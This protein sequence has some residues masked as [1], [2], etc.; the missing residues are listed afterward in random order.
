MS[1]IKSF[2]HSLVQ[3]LPVTVLHLAILAIF[4]TNFSFDRFFIGWDAI[5]P[6]LN[7]G[8]NFHRSFFA[9]WQENYGVGALT[10][11]GFAALLPHTLISFLISL[12]TPIWANRQIVTFLCLY[13]GALGMYVLMEKILKELVANKMDNQ[14]HLL[15]VLPWVSLAASFFY[16]F[17]LATIQIFFIQLEAFIFHYA[18]LPWMFLTLILFI[19]KPSKKNAFFLFLTNFIFS[20]QAFVPSLFVSYIGAVVL[21]MVVVLIS[22]RPFVKTF[23]NLLTTAFIIFC[24]NAYWFLVFA[25]YTLFKSSSFLTAYNNLIST[26]DFVDK[27]AKYG[28]FKSVALLKSF[29]LDGYQYKEYMFQPWLNHFQIPVVQGI[30]YAFFAVICLGVVLGILKSKAWKI[31]GMFLFSVFFFANIA[32]STFPFSLLIQSLQKISPTFAQAF[33]TSFSKFGLGLGFSYSVFFG[34][35]VFLVL[36]FLNRFIPRKLFLRALTVIVLIC[37]VYYGSPIFQGN[38]LYKNLKVKIPSSYQEMIHYF[39]TQPDGRIADF[40]QD[41]AEGWSTYNW[42][43]LGSGF[44]WYGIKQPILA[45]TFDVWSHTNE[46]YY[47]EILTALQQQD[48]PL[49]D[50]ILQKY[51]VRWI[52]YDE[53]KVHCRNN[54]AL[55]YSDKFLDFLKSAPNYAISQR[56]DE[57]TQKPITVFERKNEASQ[58]FLF[59]VQDPENI[60]PEVEW[61][62]ADR[63]YMS[64]G[65]Y[66]SDAQKPYDAFYPFRSLFS[67]RNPD[68][69]KLITEE[70]TDFFILREML[71]DHQKQLQVPSLAK[72]GARIPIQLSLGTDQIS[73]VAALPQIFIDTAR[74]ST[75]PSFDIKTSLNFNQNKDLQIFLN[76]KEVLNKN[77]KYESTL[78]INTDN[79]L[80]ILNQNNQT[81]FKW[82]SKN[83]PEFNQ[84][85][86]KETDYVLQ[87]TAQGTHLLTVKVPKISSLEKDFTANKELLQYLPVPC[88]QTN[89]SDDNKYEISHSTDNSYIRM[90]SQQSSQCLRI[91]LE[92]LAHDQGYLAEITLRKNSGLDPRLQFGTYSQSFLI[93]SYLTNRYSLFEKHTFLLPP[94]STLEQGYIFSLQN[95]ASTSQVSSNDIQEF[96]ITPFPYSFLE[97]LRVS[98]TKE[99]GNSTQS[100]SLLSNIQHPNETVYF[101][102]VNN[103]SP[104]STDQ[105]LVLS[106]DF[107]SGWIALKMDSFHSQLLSSRKMNSWQNSWQ[108]PS[109]QYKVMIFYWPELLTILGFAFLI[110]TFL[111]FLSSFLHKKRF[112]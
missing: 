46:Q 76:G 79:T 65:N 96:K 42:G 58:S 103:S 6:E 44:L 77:G 83:D 91:P 61:L 74:I 50:Q 28:D 112:S 94:T 19:E 10:G 20:V 24:A 66:F 47:W 92:D 102:T 70:T 71:P 64:E 18:G 95:S 8:L 108:L 60:G 36:Q 51:N 21:F 27:S 12:I 39:N 17:N 13:V 97:S 45:R 55:L 110:S 14:K 101:V 7:Y 4:L 99:K 35:G 73:V 90:I 31:R 88:G 75:D 106:Q 107:D 87:D 100:S 67:R 84:F 52:V 40:P 32:I 104:T 81:L 85:I 30:G 80:L 57:G 86:S 16:L 48:F 54:D 62:N 78:A 9:G 11:H 2:F 1:R 49:A 63:A 26:P 34:I 93:D 111:F 38:F 29:F 109:G 37:L 25:Y 33:R 41:C 53:N 15:T 56:W 43:Y 23:R 3:Y 72:M 69:K 89:S 5:N 59:T 82:Q 68:E 105:N 98:A 22:K